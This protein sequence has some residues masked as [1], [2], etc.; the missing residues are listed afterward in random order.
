MRKLVIFLALSLLIA[1]FAACSGRGAEAAQAEEP[2]EAYAIA[3]AGEMIDR[4]AC[5][6]RA[7]EAIYQSLEGGRV[8]R[9]SDEELSDVF[10]LEPY[11][12]I[13]AVVYLS[14]VSA[15]LRDIAIVRP[16]PDMEEQARAALNQYTAERT[17]YFRNYDILGSY[18]IASGAVVFNQ[19]EHL[20]ML[21]LP[22]NDA[23]REILDQYLPS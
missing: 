18:S 11:M 1:S 22:D 7:V 9:I 17:A 19:G 13:E 14:D 16:A 10:G 15:G 5:P 3:A 21:M 20:V 12:V 23:A 6:V 2:E 8:S 4:E